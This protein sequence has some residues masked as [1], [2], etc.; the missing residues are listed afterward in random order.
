M[1]Q[2]GNI[3]NNQEKHEHR[4]LKKCKILKKKKNLLDVGMFQALFRKKVQR[5]FFSFYSFQ[6]FALPKILEP[7]KYVRSCKVSMHLYLIGYFKT[8]IREAEIEL[9]SLFCGRP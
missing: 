6:S 5:T 8:S 4:G 2:T 9:Q 3:R 7:P 1:G